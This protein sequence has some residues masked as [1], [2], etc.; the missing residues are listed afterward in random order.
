MNLLRNLSASLLVGLVLNLLEATPLPAAGTNKFAPTSKRNADELQSARPSH[1]AVKLNVPG[2]PNF[3]C[4]TMNLYRGAQPTAEG[5][6][7]LKAMGIRTV[8]NLRAFHSDKDELA[9]SDLRG[10]VFTPNPGMAKSR[11]LSGF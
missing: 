5:M 3:Y 11:T 10:S 8:V 4:V 6:A 2:V 1:W 9:G 7:Q